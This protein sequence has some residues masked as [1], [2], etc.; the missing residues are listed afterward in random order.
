MS[1]K[2]IGTKRKS[3]MRTKNTDIPLEI[4][5]LI[6]SQMRLFD[7]DVTLGEIMN[8]DIPLKKS[9]MMAR[10]TNLK[11]SRERFEKHGEIDSYTRKEM[12][13]GMLSG[14]IPPNSGG[15]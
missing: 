3:Y 10:L 11:K 14:L 9:L 4:A 1:E 7:G 8:L 5:S 13:N 12:S 6:D 15:T 2:D